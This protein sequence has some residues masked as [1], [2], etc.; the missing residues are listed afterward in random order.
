ML[1]EMGKAVRAMGRSS[2]SM[3]GDES[4][5]EE[6]FM[7]WI[8]SAVRRVWEQAFSDEAVVGRDAGNG[9][10]RP[11]GIERLEPRVLLSA[12]TNSSGITI[13]ASGAA[14]PYPS[15]INF[16]EAQVD[17]QAV[18]VDVTLND[19]SHTF[20]DDIDVLLVGPTGADAILMSDAGGGA[21]V[22][23]IDLT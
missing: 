7:G 8:E 16:S 15:T 23:N 19:L 18:D 9:P 20:P 5:N 21:D 3:S 6:N 12:V 1:K 4:G 11:L 17:A 14:T 10:G 22:S 2:S 13:P